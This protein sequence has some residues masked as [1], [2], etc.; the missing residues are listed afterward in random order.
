[1][2]T[3][4][5]LKINKIAFV[6]P[7]EYFTVILLN[8]V[9]NLKYGRDFISSSSK[10]NNLLLSGWYHA[11]RNILSQFYSEEILP[12]LFKFENFYLYSKV[13]PEMQIL[14]ISDVESLLVLPAIDRFHKELINQNVKLKT[15]KL[16]KLDNLTDKIFYFV[17]PKE[18][19]A[20]LAD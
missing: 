12:K 18:T 6:Q 4:R 9:G 8:S 5:L 10:P 16:L 1:M 14:V 19:E 7:E 17:S 2:L 20:T 13:R 15:G 3:T 11:F